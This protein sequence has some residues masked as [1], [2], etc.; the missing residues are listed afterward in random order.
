MATF[1]L[2]DIHGWASVLHQLLER[3]PFDP[4]RDRLWL[5]GDLVHRGPDSLGVLRWARR[6][7]EE[8][9]ERF[10]VVLG[11]HDLKLLAEAAL[12]GKRRRDLRP[13]HAADDGAALLDWLR[14]RPL[15]HEEDGAVLVHAGLW[16]SWTVADAL[17]AGAEVSE[18]LAANDVRSR[19]LLAD[20][21]PLAT[22]PERG[23]SNDSQAELRRLARALYAFTYLRTC[24]D[25]ERPCDFSG[26]LDDLPP[27]CLPW[28]TVPGRRS[29]GE[30]VVFGHWAALGIHRSDG[31]TCLDAGCAW[32][33]ALA[34]LCLDDGTLV[35]EP[36]P[37]SG[38]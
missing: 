2:G 11:N 25:G 6:M 16:P 10:V 31:V 8:M 33:G 34:A 36:N 18:V 23:D 30:K 4:R 7:H 9:G 15:I 28:F 27:G 35:Q 3:L 26:G 5:V 13:I 29:A 21:L 24:T 22:A 12:P 14:R 1:V 17:A 20:L 37:A 38:R 32:G 19:R